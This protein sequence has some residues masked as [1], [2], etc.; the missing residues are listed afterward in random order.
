MSSKVINKET[1]SQAADSGRPGGYRLPAHLPA[2]LTPKGSWPQAG[3]EAAEKRTSASKEAVCAEGLGPNRAPDLGALSSVQEERK[4]EMYQ[5]IYVNISVAEYGEN[6][7]KK[8]CFFFL[9][10]SYTVQM[11][12]FI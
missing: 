2:F 1:G 6:E 10:I 5:L 12:S 8:D 4:C 9:L 7:S 3:C 11:N